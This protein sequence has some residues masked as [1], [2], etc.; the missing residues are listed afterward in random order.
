MMRQVNEVVITGIIKKIYPQIIT[1]AGVV[2]SRFVL[3]HES[4]QIENQQSRRVHCKMFCVLI[5][6][7]LESLMLE[8]QVEVRGFLNI[9]LQK[10]LILHINKIKKLD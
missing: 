5:G 7:K 6:D 2:V 9:N 1:P 8:T 10:Q 3:E 4:S